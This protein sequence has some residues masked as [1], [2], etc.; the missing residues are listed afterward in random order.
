LLCN[1]LPG[2]LEFKTGLQPLGALAARRLALLQLTH[3]NAGGTP[4]LPGKFK[5][6]LE[7][8][9]SVF[10]STLGTRH[11]TLNCM[12]LPAEEN[13]HSFVAK[14]PRISL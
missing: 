14:S 13:S 9:C 10:Y 2:P 11:S 6:K 4:A 1:L 7:L 5:L 3:P 8:Q 12:L